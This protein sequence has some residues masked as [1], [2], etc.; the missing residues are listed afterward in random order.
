MSINA[1]HAGLAVNQAIE[2]SVIGTVALWMGRAVVQLFKST[3]SVVELA[4]R[5]FA[6]PCSLIAFNALTFTA[7]IVLGAALYL[8]HRDMSPQVPFVEMR[9]EGDL[10]DLLMSPRSPLGTSS[11]TFHGQS[12]DEIVE[13]VVEEA[14]LEEDVSSSVVTT[15]LLSAS[16]P[17]RITQFTSVANVSMERPSFSGGEER[18]LVLDVTDAHS[19]ASVAVLSPESHADAAGSDEVEAAPVAQQAG[20]VVVGGGDSARVSLSDASDDEGEPRVAAT[21]EDPVTVVSTDSSSEAGG[22]VVSDGGFEV[23]ARAPR[24]AVR[25][26]CGPGRGCV[27]M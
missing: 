19:V 13:S 3:V 5:I 1:M 8:R 18:P 23:R 16:P 27:V 7:S 9:I 14:V 22:S 6:I 10:E 24:H 21:N 2:R 15:N 25:A 12:L 20:S 17:Q 11:E 26:G 4:S